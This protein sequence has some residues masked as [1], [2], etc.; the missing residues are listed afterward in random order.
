VTRDGKPVAGA[1]VR[2]FLRSKA[3]A[4]AGP[5]PIAGRNGPVW[6]TSNASGEVVLDTLQKIDP[7]DRSLGN[8]IYWFYVEPPGLAPFFIGPVQAGADLG[9]LTAGPLL[10]VRGEVRGTP[11]ELDAFAA[12]WDQPVPMRRGNGAVGWYYAESQ[13]LQTERAGDRLTFRLT[14]LRPGPLRIVARFR[15][16]GKPISHEYTRRVPNEDDVT[17]EVELTE[18][19]HDLVLT[20]RQRP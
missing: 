4:S 15:T 3:G 14:G 13:R 7:A 18:S 8:S 16:G 1:K 9:D 6:A 11:E 17:V 10:E 19:R 2:R 5:Y 20:N 12:E